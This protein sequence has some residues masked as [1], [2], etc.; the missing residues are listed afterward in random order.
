MRLAA[1]TRV[2]WAL[3][4]LLTALL[5]GP[6]EAR[7]QY[8]TA[9]HLAVADATWLGHQCTGQVNVLWDD[10]LSDHGFA[11]MATGMH[12]PSEDVRTWRFMRCEVTLDP[13]TWVT[14]TESQRC[15][16]MVHEVGHLSYHTHAE[17]GVMTAPPEPHPACQPPP[18]VFPLPD[19]VQTFST[20]EPTRIRVKR[21]IRRITG[22]LARCGAYRRPHL[23]CQS[24]G[25]RYLVTVTGRRFRLTRV[26]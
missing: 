22:R 19:V 17:G 14:L 20:V 9:R 4:V 3:L 23:H 2:G 12:A 10:T 26:H 24:A 1:V 8:D 5:L 21:A 16:V 13:G 7:G 25:R 18:Q 15:D 6:P 11:G